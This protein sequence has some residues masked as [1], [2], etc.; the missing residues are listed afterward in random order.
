MPL[1]VE[2]LLADALALEPE[3]RATLA[4]RLLDSFDPADPQ[5]DTL[6][7]AEARRR[8]DAWRRG[9]SRLLS[10]Q[11]FLTEIERR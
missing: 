1:V 9:E 4:E 11:E 10:E 6:W 8:L 7:M 3:E 5:T 2:R